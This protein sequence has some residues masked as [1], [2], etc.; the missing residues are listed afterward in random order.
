MIGLSADVKI[1]K[2]RNKRSGG[3]IFQKVP[4]KRK[5]QCKKTWIFHLTL[6]GVLSILMILSIK[7]R[8]E[9]REVS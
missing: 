6:V 2:T 7:N 4:S 3:C 9:G 1:L 8:G 5:L